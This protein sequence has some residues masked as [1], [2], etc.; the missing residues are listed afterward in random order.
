MDI[1]KIGGAGGV[2]P[3]KGPNRTDLTTA[4]GQK[5]AIDTLSVYQIAI[6][7]RKNPQAFALAE[8]AG[9]TPVQLQKLMRAKAIAASQPNDPAK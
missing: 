8:T 7:L 4:Q 5:E 1:N 2:N 3:L 6:H 9:L